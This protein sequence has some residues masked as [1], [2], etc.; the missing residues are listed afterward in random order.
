[1]ASS[2]DGCATFALQSFHYPR[3]RDSSSIRL[4]TIRDLLSS[5]TGEEVIYVVLEDYSL[6]DVPTYN[7][8]SYTWGES[9]RPEQKREMEPILAS[10]EIYWQLFANFDAEARTFVAGILYHSG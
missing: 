8:L 1:M 4:L 6:Y 3:L 9:E 7:A 2:P 10:P 5:H